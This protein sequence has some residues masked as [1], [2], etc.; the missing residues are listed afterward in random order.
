MEEEEVTHDLSLKSLSP[1]DEKE[2]IIFV[3]V[4][5]SNISSPSS[6]PMACEMSE[7]IQ[8]QNQLQNW[9]TMTGEG[10]GICQF[11]ITNLLCNLL[12]VGRNEGQRKLGTAANRGGG[13]KVMKVKG[14]KM[15]SI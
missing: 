3:G 12:A 10:L 14:R 7:D 5:F 9:T 13:V 6:D 15:L 11:P 8:R 2:V 4:L 1:R